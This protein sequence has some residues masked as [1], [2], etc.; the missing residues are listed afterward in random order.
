MAI[1]IGSGAG[2]G[3]GGG[4]DVDDIVYVLHDLKLRQPE[5]VFFVFRLPLRLQSFV[6]VCNQNHHYRH[7]IQN[8][9]PA[10]TKSTLFDLPQFAQLYPTKYPK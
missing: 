7:P 2:F 8:F 5:N 10:K 9:S 6:T 4:G 1:Y 3:L